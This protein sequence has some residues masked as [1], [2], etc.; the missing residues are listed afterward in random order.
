MVVSVTPF[1]KS[2]LGSVEA[3]LVI[4]KRWMRPDAFVSAGRCLCWTVD[5]AV[6]DDHCTGD[7]LCLYTSLPLCPQIDCFWGFRG[8][9]WFLEIPP[10]LVVNSRSWGKQKPV[11]NFPPPP[12]WGFRGAPKFL[13]IPP[14]L[15]RK[16]KG[17]EKAR[18]SHQLPPAP[19]I[20][21]PRPITHLATSS[22]NDYGNLG[23]V[24]KS[25]GTALTVHL[26]LK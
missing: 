20:V 10:E 8:A 15:V 13:E 17:L 7:V 24:V 6:F 2:T 9:P 11:T 1:W 22:A 18:V 19:I 23:K 26:T 14:K 25:Q 12:I 21:R 3:I 16:F 4:F 5:R